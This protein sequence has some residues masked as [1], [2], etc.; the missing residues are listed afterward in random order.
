MMEIMMMEIMVSRRWRWWSCD[1]WR[2]RS[3]EQRW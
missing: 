1:A 3:K 2:W